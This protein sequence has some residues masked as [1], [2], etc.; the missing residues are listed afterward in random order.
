MVINEYMMVLISL[1]GDLHIHGSTGQIA[2]NIKI[3]V[4]M[5]IT[6][7]GFIKAISETGRMHSTTFTFYPA[8]SE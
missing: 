7:F 1:V 8:K 5:I 4:A 6:K 2:S 3:S